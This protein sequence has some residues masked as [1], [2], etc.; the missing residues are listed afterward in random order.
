MRITVLGGGGAWPTP[1][2]GC[3]GYLIEEAGFRLL[4]DP[5]YATVPR[6]LEIMPAHGIDAVFV[7]HGHPDHCA[8]LNP[9]LRARHLSNDPP[10]ALPVFALAGALDA[11]LALDGQMLVRDYVL[12]N[13]AAGDLLTVGPFHLL[14]RSLRHFLPNVGVR[15]G[16]GDVA[17]AYTGDGG[18]DPDVVTLAAGVQVLLAEATFPEHV[19]EDSRG[20]LGSAR[21]AGEHA[22][23]ARAGQLV[24]THLWPG[25]DPDAAARA[26]RQTF[27]GPVSVAVPGLQIELP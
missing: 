23:A 26:A 24:L 8:D 25:T 11:V 6:L 10:P 12:H 18:A 9:L 2:R 17:I 16:I 13:F 20:L 14:T 7:S 4:I 5:G 22:S 27:D 19:P 21:Q 3:S 15:L 1:E